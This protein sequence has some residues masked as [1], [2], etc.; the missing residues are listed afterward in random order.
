MHKLY[1]L[2]ITLFILSNISFSQ[3]LVASY[4]LPNATTYNSL[5]GITQLNDTLWLGS[6]AD[7]IL[8]KITKTGTIIS[9][10]STPHTFN[11]GLA[12]DGTGFWIARD[13][14]FLPTKLF[15]SRTLEVK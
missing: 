11:H 13:Y 5:W 15:R 6:D 9:N 4:P 1:L 12:W 8:Y 7:G 14:N 3:T 2:L 10:L